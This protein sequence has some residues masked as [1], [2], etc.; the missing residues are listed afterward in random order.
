MRAQRGS[1]PDD[2]SQR[3]VQVRAPTQAPLKSPTW[4][5]EEDDGPTAHPTAQARGDPAP[6][7][8]PPLQTT[9]HGGADR[10]TNRALGLDD[11]QLHPAPR[12]FLLRRTNARGIA[13]TP[14]PVTRATA[15]ALGAHG[16][17]IR[18][19]NWDLRRCPG[20][21][22]K[23][24]RPS[25]DP[26]GNPA[27]APIERGA[28]SAHATPAAQALGPIT[29]IGHPSPNAHPAGHLR[30]RRDHGQRSRTSGRP[31]GKGNRPSLYRHSRKPQPPA[32]P[33]YQTHKGGQR[34]IVA[35]A[36]RRAPSRTAAPPLYQT[37]HPFRRPR[38]NRTRS[39][40]A[41]RQRG[42]PGGGHSE[43]TPL[44]PTAW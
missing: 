22:T 10:L 1:R 32:P 11:P 37:R 4:G 5:N 9:A 30:Q 8:V 21:T 27:R 35:K 40:H 13:P 12:A 16:G 18:L 19:N 44:G 43:N 28:A 42:S 17:T 34:H 36:T 24:P 2:K 3:S 33:A 38:P 20:L 26:R 14:A 23:H 29:G 41:A 15:Q 31:Y 39:R 25:I 7:R 6:P